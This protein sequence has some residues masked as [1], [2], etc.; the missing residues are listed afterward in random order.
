MA[1]TGPGFQLGGTVNFSES[2]VTNASGGAGTSEPDYVSMLGLASKLRENSSRLS[3]D[4]N[5]SLTTDFYA[6][7]TEPTQIYN[8][9]QALGNVDVVPE[10]LNVNLRAFAQPVVTSNLGA[11]SAGDR[12]IPGT[13]RDSY[14]YFGTPDFTF[15]MG[16][17]ASSQT[18]PSYGQIFFTTPD[19]TTAANSIP[20]L[21]GPE[22]TTI[23]SITE[24]VLSG[25]DFDRL[26]WKLTGVYSE[27]DRT[28]NLLTEKTGIADV[29]YAIDYQWSLLLT[30][31]YDAINDSTPLMRNVSGPVALAGFGLKLGG[32]F[33]FDI[34]A[35]E[36]YNN[37]SIISSLRYNL[38]PT[39]VITA[40]ANDYVQTPEG[41]L[42]NNLTGL[43]ALADGSLTSSED[44]FG[45]GTGSSLGSFSL[46][47][48][49]NPSL[50]QFISRYQ[51]ANISWVEQ[52]QRTNVSVSLFGTRRTYL[53]AGFTGPDSVFS[54]GTRLSVSR[55]I[56]PLLVAT[57]GAAYAVNQEFGGQAETITAQGQLSYSLSPATRV[58]LSSDYVT[59][60]SS[61]SL[62]TLSPL[63]GDT[64]DFRAL[65]GIS[66]DL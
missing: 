61:Q 34:E 6:Q 51:I 46:Q 35:G 62:Q 47:S 7:N 5:Y 38:S 36:R 26:N 56:T 60:T 8:Y 12:V 19:G 13:F 30:G 3:L 15:N 1:P 25:T 65:V 42:L 16:D 49:D 14:G 17:F 43:S 18:T 57:L 31:G 54:W 11:V 33:A 24:S 22:N 66:H 10:Y 58:Y 37:L 29:R 53:V 2:Y 21:S 32:D 27:T 52:L 23:R 45:N 40:S 41:Q 20:G 59:R 48:Q 55:N 44:A 50:D 39:S 9:L 28:Q 64:S 63:I 4:A